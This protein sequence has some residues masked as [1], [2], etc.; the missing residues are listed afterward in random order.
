MAS[1]DIEMPIPPL[2]NVPTSFSLIFN[3]T[4]S[5][6]STIASFGGARE[7][8]I[9]LEQIEDCM[10]GQ[11]P[12]FLVAPAVNEQIPEILRLADR[13]RVPVFFGLGSK[14]IFGLSYEQLR[15]ILVAPVKF[16]MCNFSESNT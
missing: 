4:S 1:Y 5:G 9:P 3:E 13:Y 2:D 15:D 7:V 6:S 8:P 12:C 10:S 16:A 11:R 14:Q